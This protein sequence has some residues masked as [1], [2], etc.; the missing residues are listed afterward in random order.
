MRDITGE[1]SA[2]LERQTGL[3]APVPGPEHSRRAVDGRR[4]ELGL[5]PALYAARLQQDA[6]EGQALTDLVTVTETWFFRDL[7][8]FELLAREA[9]S[10]RRAPKVLC[11]PCSSGEEAYSAAIY[12]HEAG[13]MEFDI[14]GIDICRPALERAREGRY[15]R[16]SFRENAPPFCARYF[17][18]E[19]DFR[20]A[21]ELKRNVVFKQGNLL[22]RQTLAALPEFDFIFCRNMLIYLTPAARLTVLQNLLE[23]LRPGGLL[24]TGHSEISCA[25]CPGLSPTGVRGSFSLRRDERKA[26]V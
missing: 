21:E 19:G 4:H 20:I 15:S 7:I 10:L 8:P 17:R 3:D 23:R 18:D 12:L 14:H 25:L 24:F 13:L 9:L 11:A 22:E 2:L 5:S 16:H 1:I 6:E 26:Q